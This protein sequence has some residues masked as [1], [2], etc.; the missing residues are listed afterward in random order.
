MISLKAPLIEE[1]IYEK[2]LKEKM[3]L[4]HQEIQLKKG[5]YQNTKSQRKTYASVKVANIYWLE[6]LVYLIIALFLP[7]KILLK[8]LLFLFILII[9]KS[10]PYGIYYLEYNTKRYYKLIQTIETKQIILQKQLQLTK[11]YLKNS[12]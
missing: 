9:R 10:I 3:Q 6:Y 12:K 5:T 4:K 1:R 7:Q 8:L 11:K 2:F